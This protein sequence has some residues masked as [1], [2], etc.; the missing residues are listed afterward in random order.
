MGKSAD[1]FRTISEVAEWL[2]VQSHVLRF[3]ESKFPQVKPV[4]RAG[5]RRYYRP[6]DML[7]LGGIRKLLHAD[8]LTI[9]G[10][11][12]IL[13]EEGIAHVADMSQ[14]LDDDTN[15]QLDGDLAGRTPTPEETASVDVTPP[16]EPDVVDV[17]LEDADDADD[18]EM[19]DGLDQS[20]IKTL[21]EDGPFSDDDEDDDADSGQDV[22]PPTYAPTAIPPFMRDPKMDAAALAEEERSADVPTL[23]SDFEPD[24]DVAEPTDKADADPQVPA[25]VAEQTPNTQEDLPGPFDERKPDATPS[26]PTVVP[27]PAT[28][29][30]PVI[31]PDP[32]AAQDDVSKDEPEDTA[33]APM[34]QQR[35]TA[36]DTRAS[37]PEPQQET[38]ASAPEQAAVAPID[39]TPEQ[40]QDPAPA[41]VL[42][43]RIVDVPDDAVI[44]EAAITPSALSKSAQLDH[45]TPEQRDA[46]RP[47]VAQLT[48]LRDQMTGSHSDPS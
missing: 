10:V 18:Q 17:Q 26:E 34:F 36:R 6:A 22:T 28:P 47:L 11:Q 33:P 27:D 4:K 2:G 31:T 29:P 43:P 40:A 8:G 35:E 23:T 46:I 37:D 32:V 48:A 38:A 39:T 21:T 44:N 3:W 12:K 19:P 42:R 41:A 20:P 13:R 14:P 30:E 16:T 9:K 5:G 7:L 25:E 1:A 45:L 15:A 24:A